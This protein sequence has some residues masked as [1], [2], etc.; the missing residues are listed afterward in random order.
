VA[1]ASA[2]GGG[3]TADEPSRLRAT[4]AR[5]HADSVFFTVPAVA[6]RCSGG[7]SSL[8]LQAAD[9]SGDG[10]LALVRRG[11]SLANGSFPLI[12]LGDSITQRGANVAVRY[13]KVDMA[14]GLSLDS[15]AVELTVAADGLA[16]RV[17]GSGLESGVRATLDAVFAGVPLP[18]PS[19]TVPCRFVP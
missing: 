7:G 11:D 4:I 16:G 3:G 15:G 17:R 12:L 13:M 5:P 10:V 14:H 8:L 9:E 2:C 19:D 6:H 1:L 18:P